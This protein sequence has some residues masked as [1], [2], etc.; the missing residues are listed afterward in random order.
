MSVG[1]LVG[2][3][4]GVAE[5]VGVRLAV[6]DGVGVWVRVAVNVGVRVAGTN[7]VFV[8]VKVALGVKLGVE[9][10]SGMGDT[11]VGEAV[12]LTVGVSRP[13]ARR[14]AIRPAQ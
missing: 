4:V 8:A 9:L 7:G 12:G 10:A 13:G 6:V 2:S 14:R 3:T 1:V 5:A 11:C